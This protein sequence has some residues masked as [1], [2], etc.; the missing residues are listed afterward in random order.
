MRYDV[1]LAT[2]IHLSLMGRAWRERLDFSAILGLLFQATK[3]YEASFSSKLV[4]TVDPSKPVIDRVVL[5]NLRLRLPLSGAINR[6]ARICRIYSR[7]ISVFSAYL[8]TEEGIYLIS[9]FR[10]TYANANITE[11]KM[12]DL[13]LWQ[14]RG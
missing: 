12:L 13:V 10:R 11:V 6:E 5:N 2:T 9:A 3:R 7:L 14:T 8:S 4:A 1:V